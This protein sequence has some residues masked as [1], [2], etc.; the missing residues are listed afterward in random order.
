MSK[1]TPGGLWVALPKQQNA[2]NV[3][4]PVVDINSPKVMG[5]ISDIVL[6]EY[7]KAAVTPEQTLAFLSGGGEVSI[8]SRKRNTQPHK[9]SQARARVR[10]P[11]DP[12]LALV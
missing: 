6:Q 11:D 2:E 12:I 4:V 1:K 10:L 7:S 9:Q 8:P 5:L 3:Y